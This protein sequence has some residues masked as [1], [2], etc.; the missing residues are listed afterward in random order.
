MFRSFGGPQV[1]FMSTR[2]LDVTAKRPPKRSRMQ[3]DPLAVEIGARIRAL[4]VD[5][6]MTGTAL[7][8][9][10]GIPATQLT[11]WERGRVAPSA[12]SILVLA[13]ALGSEPASLLPAQD[14]EAHVLAK[15][16]ALLPEAALPDLARF[17]AILERAHGTR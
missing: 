8:A 17:L 1:E 6:G 7:A 3:T 13:R 14:L 16:V 12:R 9:E 5:R 2:N 4:R 10:L 15:R 11:A